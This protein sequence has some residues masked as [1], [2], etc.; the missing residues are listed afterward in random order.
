MPTPEVV[1]RI[2][3][4]IS[5][6]LLLIAALF[7]VSAGYRSVAD[8][9]PPRLSDKEFW[10]MVTDFSE[11]GG[12][13]RSDNFLS[14][15]AG[16]QAVIPSLRRTVH[17]GG[18]YLGVGPE[19]NFTYILGIEPKMAFIVDIRRQNMLEHLLYKALIELS[20]DRPD[21]LSRLFSRPKPAGLSAD[22]RADVLFRA[23]EAAQPSANL[24]DANNASVLDYLEN[25]KGFGLT[26][27]DE[28]SVRH[29]YRAF[30][31]SGPD[32][33]YTFFGGYGSFM[34]MPTYAEFMQENDGHTRNWSF[35]A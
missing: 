9:L 1:R 26:T 6:T 20:A 33:S 15:E 10:N 5:A 21:F 7:Y 25:K 28:A 16:Y 17:T 18:V 24:F 11:A 8:T 29:V 27:E 13:F 32:L 12:Y 4:F 19:Q 22:S 23:Y 31:E 3:L 14:N 34:G 30:Y 35:L 2:I